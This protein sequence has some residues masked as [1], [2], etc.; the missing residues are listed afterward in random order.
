LLSHLKGK[1]RFRVFKNTKFRGIHILKRSD[2]GL[3]KRHNEDIHDLS[4]PSNTVL[5][6]EKGRSDEHMWDNFHDEH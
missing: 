3:K 4:S 2:R 1:Q 5:L 6:S